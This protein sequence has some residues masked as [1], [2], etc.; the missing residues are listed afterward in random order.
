MWVFL[1]RAMTY[2]EVWVLSEVWHGYHDALA[3]PVLSIP[4]VSD[5]RAHVRLRLKDPDDLPLVARKLQE[6]LGRLHDKGQAIEA[7]RRED[8]ERVRKA[9]ESIDWEA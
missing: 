4:H 2:D 8:S 1:N 5:D 6:L 7:Q 3:V 9:A